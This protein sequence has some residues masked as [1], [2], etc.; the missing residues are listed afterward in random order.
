MISWVRR[1]LFSGAATS[2]LQVKMLTAILIIYVPVKR[3]K[4]KPSEYC[5]HN[6]F[7]KLDLLFSAAKVP[8]P[9][10]TSPEKDGGC[11]YCC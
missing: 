5:A 9:F 11:L 1:R 8:Q 10:Y 7:K 3:M 6:I 2:I 4:N